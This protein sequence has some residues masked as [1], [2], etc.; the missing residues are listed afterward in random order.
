MLSKIDNLLDSITMYRLVLYCLMSVHA[1]A[2]L[3]TGLGVLSITTAGLATSLVLL[4][5]VCWISNVMVAR[6]F[7]VQ[8]NSESA[9]ITALILA[10]ILPPPTT[11]AGGVG[12]AIAGLIAM[13]SKYVVARQRTHLFNPAAFAAV[14]VGVSGL[15]HATWWVA[16]PP[17]LPFVLIQGFLIIRKTRRLA[18]VNIFIMVALAMMLLIG[19]LNGFSATSILRNAVLSWPL[20][21]FATVMLTEPSTM[22]STRYYRNVFAALV[23]L[24]F[25]AQ[26]HL[27]PISSTPEVALVVGN[28]FAAILTP[29]RRVHLT[30]KQKDKLANNIYGF[31]FSS[32]RPLVFQ[33]GQYLEWTLAHPHLDGRGNRRTFTIASSPTETDIQLAAKFYEPSS[34]YKRALSTLKPGDTLFAG[35]LAGDFTLPADR[36]QK[37]LFIAGGIGI[38]PFRSMIKYLVDTNQ[39]RAVALLYVVASAS[40]I[41]YEDLLAEAGRHGIDVRYCVTNDQLPTNKQGISGPLTTEVLGELTPD[42]RERIIY[43]SGPHAMVEYYRAALRAAGVSAKRIKSDHFSGY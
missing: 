41:A 23:G 13:V 34:S 36:T 27:G 43:I 40:D 33:P 31:T 39:E 4:M 5:V 14:V 11:I 42:Y 21:F 10:L 25:A 3:F 6:L 18:M 26:I 35:Q 15:L 37:L 16:T 20:L 28:L 32:D 19:T 12:V 22:P 24:V 7:N 29:K 30:L 2:L 17:M 1:I 38:T 8:A 9:F